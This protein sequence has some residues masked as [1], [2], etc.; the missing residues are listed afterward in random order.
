[1][2]SLSG[3]ARSVNAPVFLALGVL[4]LLF[5]GY[6]LF[7]SGAAAHKGDLISTL[8]LTGNGKFTLITGIGGDA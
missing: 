5:D 7:V 6:D 3:A 8:N 1:M 2:S 4:I